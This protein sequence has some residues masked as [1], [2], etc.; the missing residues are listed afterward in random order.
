MPKTKSNK[1]SNVVSISRMGR[2]ARDL[3]SVIDGQERER[4][5]LSRELH[6]GV[7]QSLIVIKL[8]LDGLAYMEE[9]QIREKLPQIQVQVDQII[10]ELRRISTDLMPAVLDEFGIIIA[11]RNLCVDI[12][13]NAH[14]RV[15]F[16]FRGD[17]NDLNKK[18]M[19]YL[20][21]IVQEALNNV[22][23]H[24]GATNVDVRLLRE[25]DIIHLS[26]IDDGK[27]FNINRA[28]PETGHGLQNIKERVKLMN[29]KF[30][31]ISALNKGT[32]ILIEAP[33][34]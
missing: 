21:R 1:K 28:Y 23:K 32:S 34:F 33:V 30:E 7:G 2:E 3:R 26:V 4:Q 20:F 18:V 13:K 14:I 5:R 12:E 9:N 10:D 29:G 27:G 15:H 22:V 8:K 19:T 17:M 25:K 11:L 24:A 31:I 16:E 6:D